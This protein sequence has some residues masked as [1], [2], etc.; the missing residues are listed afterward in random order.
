[1]DKNKYSL[2]ECFVDIQNDPTARSLD[3]QKATHNSDKKYFFEVFL[4]RSFKIG[5]SITK[6]LNQFDD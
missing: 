4:S 5:G 2:L 3:E 6:L 1:M